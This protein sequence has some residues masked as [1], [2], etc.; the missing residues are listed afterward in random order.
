MRPRN[1]GDRS[2][3]TEGG[4]KR[5]SENLDA[6]TKRLGLAPPDSLSQVFAGWEALVGELM[7]THIHPVGL[8]NGVLTVEVTEPAWATQ[9]KFLGNDLIRQI[10]ERV[11]AGTVTELSVR[12]VSKRRKSSQ[13]DESE[14]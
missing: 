12:V 8:R 6:L 7:A 5:L 4:I 13:H 10:N 1:A 3:D 9:L 14:R 2:K 11:G